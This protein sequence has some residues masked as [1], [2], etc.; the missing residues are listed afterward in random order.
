[1]SKRALAGVAL[2]A[3]LFVGL[4]YEPDSGTA[5]SVGPAEYTDLLVGQNHAKPLPRVTTVSDLVRTLAP[6]TL[7]LV[8]LPVLTAGFV[9][10]VA[11]ARDDRHRTVLRSAVG[12]VRGPPALAGAPAR[13]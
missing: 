13:G 6:L 4:A 10:L 9:A 8:V 2:L 5:A 1:M 7:L 12:A 11:L 3:C